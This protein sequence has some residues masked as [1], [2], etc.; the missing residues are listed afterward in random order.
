MSARHWDIPGEGFDSTVV[1]LGWNRNEPSTTV[2]PVG[3]WVEVKDIRELE[4]PQALLESEAI[5]WRRDF[6]AIGLGFVLG[7]LST[8]AVQGVW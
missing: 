8:L 7:V 5:F 4:S 6:D 3:E 1:E 2:I